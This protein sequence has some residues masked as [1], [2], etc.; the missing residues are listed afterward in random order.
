MARGARGRG[1]QPKPM[2]LTWRGVELAPETSLPSSYRSERI[3]LTAD[4]GADWQVQRVRDSWC[5]R[6][7]VGADRFPGDGD[8]PEAALDAAAAEAS[9]VL[10][11]TRVALKR[12]GVPSQRGRKEG[13]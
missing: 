12:S 7:R 9:L 2:P 8:T 6:L 5:A 4:R 3:H 11:L 1:I 10:R 13:A